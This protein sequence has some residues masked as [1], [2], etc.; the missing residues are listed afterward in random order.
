MGKQRR[1]RYYN[2]ALVTRGIS[3]LNPERVPE[4]NLPEFPKVEG[5]SLRE[6][7]ERQWRSGYVGNQV[8]KAKWR[9]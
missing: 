8:R 7:M 9:S 5:E 6:L 3:K 1:R 4:I 2:G